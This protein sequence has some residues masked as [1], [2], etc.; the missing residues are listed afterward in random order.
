MEMTEKDCI[1]FDLI[2]T[3]GLVF[4]FLVID[5]YPMKPI[6]IDVRASDAAMYYISS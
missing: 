3:L 2:G 5:V 4:L 1:E 6:L